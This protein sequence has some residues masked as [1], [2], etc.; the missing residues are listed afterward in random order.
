MKETKSKLAVKSYT[1]RIVV[2]EDPF[3]D[4]TMAYHAYCPALRDH[5]ASTWVVHLV[6]ES[7]LNHGV[8]IP[9]EPEEEVNVSPEPL[10][11]V[12]IPA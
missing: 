7:L 3:E 2:E 4:R 9:T 10:V 6:I 8:A 5:G 12:T 11:T 1:F